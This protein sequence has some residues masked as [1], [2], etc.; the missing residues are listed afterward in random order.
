MDNSDIGVIIGAIGLL[1]TIIKEWKYIVRFFRWCNSKLPKFP[2]MNINRRRFLQ[3]ISVTAVVVLSGTWLYCYFKKCSSPCNREESENDLVWNKK[4]GV[5]HHKTICSG[6]LPN[7]NNLCTSPPSEMTLKI[8][9]SKIV[10]IATNL[11]SEVDEILK[12]HILVEAI[13]HNPTSTHLYRLLIKIWGKYKKYEKIHELL[14][15]NADYLLHLKNKTTYSEKLKRK[16][17]KAYNEL[18]TMQNKARRHARL[19]KIE[20]I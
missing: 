15:A 6:H 12:E 10:H 8:H 2:S 1:I 18:I 16:F 13:K 7:Q 5:V 14:D 11:S 4:N 20:R 9:S 17:T 19:Y 3:S